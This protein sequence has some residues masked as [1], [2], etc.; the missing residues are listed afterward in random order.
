MPK[1]VSVRDFML[2]DIGEFAIA[3]LGYPRHDLQTA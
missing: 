2:Q 1:A 3:S